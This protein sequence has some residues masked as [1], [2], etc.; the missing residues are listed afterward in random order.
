MATNISR[1]DLLSGQKLTA[2]P[3]FRPP[4]ALAEQAFAGL[5]TA[6]GECVK[7]C[8]EGILT[9]PAAGLPNVDFTRGEC[10]FCGA[11]AAACPTGA[12]DN[13]A[14]RAGAPA[15]QLRA[16]IGEAC[17]A[18]ANIVCRVCGERCDARAIHFPAAIGGT[19]RPTLDPRACTGCGACVAPC[20]AGAINLVDPAATPATA[21]PS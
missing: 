8:E 21:T 15:W 14:R 2:G 7:H 20:P 4:W 3:A 19:A 12:L 16:L 5:C 9:A 11:C 6:C 10:T 17:L 13:K 18:G 1:R